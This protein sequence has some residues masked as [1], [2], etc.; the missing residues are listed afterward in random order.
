MSS[1]ISDLD[2][3]IGQREYGLNLGQDSNEKSS[4]L[5]AEFGRFQS[6][7]TISVM[8]AYGCSSESLKMGLGG[9]LPSQPCGTLRLRDGRDWSILL[10]QIR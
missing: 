9:C 10:L 5:L 7:D 6:L 2:E 4:P 1:R 3:T 8:L